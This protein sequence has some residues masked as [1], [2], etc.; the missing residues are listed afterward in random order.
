MSKSEQG[1]ELR[2]DLCGRNS[3][4]ACV[5]ENSLPLPALAHPIG[6]PVF[7]LFAAPP[8]PYV[9]GILSDRIAVTSKE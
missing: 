8:F 7:E 1:C 5:A 4:G 6:V 9:W 2:T 3:D